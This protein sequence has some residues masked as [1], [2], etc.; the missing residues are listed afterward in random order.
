MM[1]NSKTR[2]S[3]L[4]LKTGILL[5]FLGIAFAGSFSTVSAADGGQEISGSAESS[6]EIKPDSAVVT[7]TAVIQA[8]ADPGSDP[9][10]PKTGDTARTGFYLF[11][12]FAS[13]GIIAVLLIR[14]LKT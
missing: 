8:P 13:A 11:A 4:L 3:H 9:D 12:I 10:D 2:L 14:L 7:V 6:E 5:L 1:K